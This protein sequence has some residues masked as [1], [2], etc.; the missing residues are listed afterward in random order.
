M[1]C[2]PTKVSS[3][4]V[5]SRSFTCLTFHFFFFGLSRHSVNFFPPDSSITHSLV[6]MQYSLYSGYA[7]SFTYAGALINPFSH[8]V[9]VTHFL[10]NTHFQLQAP[11]LTGVPT[12]PSIDCF[13]GSFRDPAVM[14]PVCCNHYTNFKNSFIVY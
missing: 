8:P 6:N 1:K 7:T 11:D 13:L 2:R 9:P 14:E 12:A 4:V 10:S 3:F 5:Q